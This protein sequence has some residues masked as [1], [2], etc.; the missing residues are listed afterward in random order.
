MSGSSF[1]KNLVDWL[2][3]DRSHHEHAASVFEDPPWEC[4][5]H[6]GV[7]ARKGLSTMC[8]FRLLFNGLCFRDAALYARRHFLGQPDH[9]SVTSTLS[10]WNSKAR[11]TAWGSIV[12]RSSSHRTL[13]LLLRYL[14][15]PWCCALACPSLFPSTQDC[16]FI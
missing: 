10:T 15:M 4:P 1:L 3:L 14:G 5:A 12:S 9:R 13:V 7:S 6:V 8:A 2:A 11:G 16:G